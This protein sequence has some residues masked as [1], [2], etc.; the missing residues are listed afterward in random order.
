EGYIPFAD[1]IRGAF[2]EVT[3][4]QIAKDYNASRGTLG[5]M[6]NA[7]L[8]NERVN[9]DIQTLM[10]KGYTVHA[11]GDVKHGWDIPGIL[12]GTARFTELTETGTRLG[13]YRRAYDR[14]IKEGLTP[15]EAGV[16]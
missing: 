6:I 10:S 13:V 16:E 4:K 11:F 12:K 2:D 14:A 7:T 5:G 8:H 9:R 15:Y 3:Q 1:A